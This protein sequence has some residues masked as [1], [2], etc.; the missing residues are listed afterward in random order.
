MGG[1][2]GGGDVGGEQLKRGHAGQRGGGERTHPLKH[3][4]LLRRGHTSSP[5]RLPAVHPET[6][7]RTGA[8]ERL[9]LRHRE[10]GAAGEVRD[11]GERA[12]GLHPG[13]GV[14]AQATDEV[15]AQP[16]RAPTVGGVGLHAGNLHVDGQDGDAVAAGVG[17]E[18]LRGVEPHGLRAQQ[19]DGEFRLVVV[20]E[21][22]GEVDE[23]REGLRVRFGEA[24]GGK[25]HH[26]GPQFLRHVAGDAVCLFEPGEEP[27]LELRHPLRG[28]LGPHGAAQLVGL[29][30]GET[31]G[32]LGHLHELFLEERDAEGF[33]QR[34]FETRVVV[35][36]GFLAVAAADVG[37]DGAALDG[38]GAHERDLHHDVEEAAWFE[39]GQ[40]GHLRA[41]FHLEHANGVGCPQ[42]RVDVRVREGD[43]PQVHVDA[44]VGFHL[45]H[46]V[47]QR[48]EHAQP[49]E[50]E[51]HQATVGGVVLV[52]LDDAAACHPRPLG[53]DDVGDGA[54]A[55]DH[56]AGVNA[57]VA[58]LALELGGEG[59]HV[60]GRLVHPA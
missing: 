43:F 47:V 18:R 15:E 29:G 56:A 16:D 30:A 58:G 45:V 44:A 57:E 24:V 32:V 6:V 28:A 42:H 19:A 54:V 3:P 26:F 2:P 10:V 7:E 20:L 49:Q 8:R 36:D 12:G 34:V 14:I 39:P 21:P 50:V 53:G 25:R 9:H 33:F 27:L 31:R 4:L 1:H 23:A 40:G 37:V 60:A 41:G 5:Q 35:G 48:A 17:N 46:H 51:F 59:E 11:G 38:P 55:D 52:P 13:G 22:G